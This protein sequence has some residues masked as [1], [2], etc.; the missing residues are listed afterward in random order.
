MAICFEVGRAFYQDK[1]HLLCLAGVL[2]L[3][4]PG[5]R[6]LCNLGQLMG[7]LR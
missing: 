5:C 2:R 7:L 3:K 1:G 4:F 6:A